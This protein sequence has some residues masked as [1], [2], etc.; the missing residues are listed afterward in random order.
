MND[1]TYNNQIRIRGLLI[2]SGWD[3]LGNVTSVSIATFNE[4]EY[5]VANNSLSDK[6]LSY[7]RGYVEAT[8]FVKDEEGVKTIKIE[9][10]RIKNMSH[11]DTLS[12]NFPFEKNK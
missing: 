3:D 6:F 12:F 1:Y 2:P 8:G 5:I 7:L 11:L 4:D 10:Y 9:D